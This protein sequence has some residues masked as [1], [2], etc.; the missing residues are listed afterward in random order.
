MDVL[1]NRQSWMCIDFGTCNTAA[2]I[3]VDGKPHIVTYG[4]MQYFPTIACV[5]QNGNIQVCQD[6]EPFRMKF[7]E[8]FKQEFKLDIGETV[9]VN[10]KNYNDIVSEILKYVKGCAEIENNSQKIN[11]VIL[12]I[13]ALY[14][15]VD[16]RIDVMR[17]AA[18]NAGFEDVEFMLEPESAAHHYAYISGINN[19]GIS[20]IYDLGGGTFDPSLIDMSNPNEP[21]VL[22]NESGV[23]CGGHFFDTIIYKYVYNRFSEDGKTLDKSN[24]LEDYATCKRL[25]ESLSIKDTASQIFSNGESFSMNRE[26]FNGLILKKIELTLESC[27]NLLH[28]SGK[29]WKDVKQVMFVGGSTVI[30]IITELLQKHLTSHNA[31]S[32]RIIRNTNGSNGVY[33]PLYATCLGGITTKMPKQTVELPKEKIAFLSV[34][35]KKIELKEGLN[36]F[37]R[38]TEN[39][40]VFADDA[41]FSRKHFTIMVTKDSNGAYSYNLTTCSGTQPTVIN[42]LE[43]LDLSLYPIARKSIMLQDGWTISAGKTI[44]IFKKY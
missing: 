31:S 34:N 19:T 6:A 22:G 39:D 35:G 1:G 16:K 15:N 33:N 14:G 29:Q 25:K 41:H 5:L 2:A 44:F 18:F 7:P 36:T 17:Q 28:S 30:P 13:P 42:N 20:L 27:D 24:K 43:A 11:S 32:V 37:G 8:G 9:D 21:K 23:K 40:F 38:S 12:T 3:L 26:T 10:G 4:N